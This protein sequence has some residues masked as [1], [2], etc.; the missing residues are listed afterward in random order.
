MIPG[1]FDDRAL[2]VVPLAKRLRELENDVAERR[3]QFRVVVPPEL[4]VIRLANECRVRRKI[5][6]QRMQAAN[7]P[8]KRPPHDIAQISAVVPAEVGL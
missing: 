2:W 8:P 3:E 5:R 6:H 4:R 7:P 1:T